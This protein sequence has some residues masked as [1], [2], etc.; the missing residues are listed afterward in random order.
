MRTFLPLSLLIASL[1]LPALATA[2]TTLEIPVDWIVYSGIHPTGRSCGAILVVE[3]DDTPDASRYTLFYLDNGRQVTRSGPP[4]DDRPLFP[5]YTNPN[6]TPEGRH[7]FSITGIHR[8]VNPNL[9]TCDPSDLIA[10]R[11]ALIGTRFQNWRM[12]VLLDNDPPTAD[13]T[14]EESTTTPLTIDFDASAS[15]DPED[16]PLSYEW[17]FGD[18][19]TGQGEQPSHT[20]TDAGTYTVALTVR[21]DVGQEDTHTER[22]IVEDKRLQYTL[23]AKPDTVNLGE[24]ITVQ[25]I[26]ENTSPVTMTEVKLDG[27]LEATSDDGGEVALASGPEPPM[28]TLEAQQKDTLRWMYDTVAEGTVSF[29]VAGQ[30][31][32]TDPDGKTVE[33]KG[34]AGC[35]FGKQG[36]L[37]AGCPVLIQVTYA[38]NSV[39][40][41]AQRPGLQGCNTG[42]TIERDG[43]EEP[44]CTLRAAIAALNARA[45]SASIT[46]DIPGT[47]PHTIAVNALLPPIEKTTEI[48]A[49]TQAGGVR[50]VAGAGVTGDGL[51]LKGTGSVVKGLNIAG[52]AGGGAGLV[53][54]GAGGHSVEGCFIGLD[55]SG[56]GTAGNEVGI[57]VE[58][59]GNTIGGEAEGQGNEVSVSV[60]AGILV[61]TAAGEVLISGNRLYANQGAGIQVDAGVAASAKASSGGIRIEGNRTEDNKQGGILVRNRPGV[62]IGG[63]D[64]DPG[65]P[66]GNWIEDGL[67]LIDAVNARIWANRIT[68][69]QASLEQGTA[70]VVRGGEGNVIGGLLGEGNLIHGT[71]QGD[72]MLIDEANQTRIEGNLIGTDGTKAMP[73]NHGIVD[74]GS[75]TLILDNHISGNRASGIFV[76]HDAESVTLIE[77]N[78]IGLD[79][80][81]EFALPNGKHGIEVQ[82]GIVKIGGNRAGE[83]CET[84]CN[85]ISGNTEDGIFFHGE[86]SDFSE[87]LGNFIGV[88]D[89]GQRP[90]G[91]GGSG[92]VAQAKM[93]IGGPSN[94][95]LSTCNGACNIIAGNSRDG[96]RT[97]TTG[98]AV[99]INRDVEAVTIN[100]GGAEGVVVQGNYIGRGLLSPETPAGSELG[101]RANGIALGAGTTG[102]L[103]G[104]DG[105]NRGNVIVRNRGA[106]VL[107]APGFDDELGVGIF[108]EGN[109]IR[110]NRIFLNGGLAIDISGTWLLNAGSGTSLDPGVTDPSNDD[111]RPNAATA[112][113]FLLGAAASSSAVSLTWIWRGGT[114]TPPGAYLIDYYASPYCTG[115]TGDAYTPVYSEVR[116]LPLAESP[117]VTSVP[118]SPGSPY[119][120][121][122]ATAPDGSTSELF[123][124]IAIGTDAVVV[125]LIDGAT[126][127]G[128]GAQ[129]TPTANGAQGK[130]TADL[131]VLYVTRHDTA[132]GGPFLESSAKTPGA[133]VIIPQSTRG[134]YWQLGTAG[135][136]TPMSYELCLDTA[137]LTET[138]SNETIVLLRNAATGGLWQPHDTYLAMRGATRY[139][140]T[141]GLTSFGDAAL[142]SGHDV[143]MAAPV[144]LAPD[145][146]S[147]HVAPGTALTWESVPEAA[148]YELQV[149]LNASF[150]AVL[151]DTSGVAGTS[152]PIAGL[153]RKTRHYWRV[154]GMTVA[155]EAGPWSAPWRFTTSDTG[156]AVEDEAEV[157]DE[158][159]LHANYPNPF[160]PQT[161]IPFAL[162]QAGPVRLVIYDV[163]GRE[164]VVLMDGTLPAGRHEAVF[165]ATGLPSGVYFYRLQ[166]AGWTRTRTMLLLK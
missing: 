96:I 132:P 162:P 53:L 93:T 17:G 81:G 58:S 14:W 139:A 47:G 41:R 122:T 21:D 142:G 137:A 111:D 147:A 98:D 87:V 114:S 46:F 69:R 102:T 11:E 134:G 22:V 12:V 133:A 116:Q 76:N 159:V 64:Q 26:V 92:I 16:Q 86:D 52:F 48:D 166:T 72:G 165:D 54:A 131:G 83:A 94:A 163:L 10:G 124:C 110:K 70:L 79:D 8:S 50:L 37:Q 84:P 25:L 89:D 20:Y 157:P 120:T 128:P 4:F 109:T 6:P 88:T 161:T 9:T 136:E 150:A 32:G 75:N 42:E 108:G 97:F 130:T 151:V 5:A 99:Q 113:V 126:A 103:I 2:Q 60:N 105:A 38:V 115:Y 160:N 91:N 80:I 100:G 39:A 82:K 36:G 63:I 68:N 62:S 51:V 143:S 45:S 144:L 44:E 164:M 71:G 74:R 35:A 106:G 127:E 65:E 117:F 112:P 57:R 1:L 155:G 138:E 146:E 18:G 24:Q 30:V 40:D 23:T 33:A 13:F 61:T 135:Q 154:R 55:A 119:F 121:A 59:D 31:V 158:A 67:L 101:N 27:T 156:V 149:A 141:G 125:P 56:G 123:N 28:L 90:E 95:Y 34:Q 118:Q 7:R 129:V 29:S 43:E 140:C 148:F 66:P 78:V 152:L 85:L 153:L 104:G 3:F 73:N 107:V 19:T 15:S 77:G 49:T 145:A